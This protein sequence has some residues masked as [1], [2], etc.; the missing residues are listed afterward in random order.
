MSMQDKVKTRVADGAS[1]TGRKTPVS[2]LKCTK[3]NQS[4]SQT[5]SPGNHYISDQMML[6]FVFEEN[7]VEVAAQVPPPPFQSLNSHKKH[8]HRVTQN[9][10]KTSLIIHQ[11]GA[12]AFHHFGYGN[13][14][15]V[16]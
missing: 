9:K 3:N 6:W 13:L 7:E 4:L 16:V 10:M 2:S 1:Q 8:S 15:P 5:T 12:T 14:S 11:I